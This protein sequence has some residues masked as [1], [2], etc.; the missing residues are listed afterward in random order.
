MQPP[1]IVASDRALRALAQA[2]PRTI[3][4]LLQVHGFGP[5]KVE[6]YGAD[7]LAVIRSGGAARTGRRGPDGARAAAPRA[8][9]AG[10]RAPSD[11]EAVLESWETTLKLWRDGCSVLAIAERRIISPQTV[12][13]HLATAIRNGEKRWICA[14]S[15]RAATGWAKSAS[16]WPTA[17][18]LSAAHERAWAGR[19]LFALRAACSA[20]TPSSRSPAGA[21]SR[22]L[23]LSYS[24][25]LLPSYPR[26]AAGISLCRARMSVRSAAM[27]EVR[28]LSVSCQ[29]PAIA[30]SRAYDAAGRP[31]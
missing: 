8:R 28:Y 30:A 13:T 12:L 31:F 11:D 16:H 29:A 2:R 7:L 14:T 27:T 17:T 26:S 22:T 20:S 23:L 24:H 10:N 15:C 18:A 1:Y 25:L 4:E 6:R 3:G 21:R 5:A 9:R 19:P